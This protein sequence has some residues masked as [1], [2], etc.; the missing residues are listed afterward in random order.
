MYDVVTVGE[1]MLRLSPPRY[2][3]I[4]RARTLD[5]Q[6]CGSQGNVAC[7]IARLGLKTAFV[8]KLPDNALGLLAND[9]YLSC[10]VDTSHIQFIPGAR[11]GVN[12]LEFGA[13][14]RASAVVYDRKNSAASTIAPDDFDWDKILQGARLAYTD[15]I[16]PGLSPT[17]R[18]A[19]VEFIAAAK[20][21]GC[22]VGF[23]VNYR[24]HLWSP[25]EARSVMSEMIKNVDILI[26]T[27]W[28]CE[29]VFGYR[30]SHEEMLRQF[31]RDFGCKIA[32]ITLREVHNVL[33]G[34]WN[35]MV[36]HEGKVLHGQKFEIDVIDRFGAG[37]SWGSG[38]LYGYLTSNDVEYALNFGNA[39]CALHHTIPGDVAHVTVKEVEALLNT[40]DFREKR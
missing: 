3:R 16:F 9:H 11:L 40:R 1:G 38:F 19:A 7:N 17:C 18:Q 6:M 33:R 26:T 32:A 24:E 13:T 39:L 34:A 36:F 29:V 35:T 37:D 5:V 10:G 31:H 12:Y 28:D 15:G 14:P 27:Q 8:T 22:L 4:R 20:R 23:D 2:E 21:N 25:E 30:S